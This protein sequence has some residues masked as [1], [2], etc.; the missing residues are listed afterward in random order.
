MLSCAGCHSLAGVKLNGPDL[1][2]VSLWPVGQLKPAIKRMEQRVGP[3]PDGDVDALADLLRAPNVRERLKA[4]EARIQAMFMA[5]LEPANAAI[6]KKLFFGKTELQNG[7]LA[8]SACHAAAGEGGN[9]GPDLTSAFSRIGETPLISGI[10][11][12]GYKIM[13][14]HYR[15]RPVTKQEAVH[16][17]KYLSTLD[18]KMAPAGRP[19]FAHVGAGGAMAAMIGLVLYLRNGR[20]GRETKL[21]RRRK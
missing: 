10:E 7:G 20:K 3:L 4:E 13:E 12:A 17:T 2:H 11:K 5:K 1:S 14:P 21:Q 16:L 9:L 15:W 8:C 18:P 19:A 6:G